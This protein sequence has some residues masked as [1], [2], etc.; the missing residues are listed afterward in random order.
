MKALTYI[1]K[2]TVEVLETPAP[3]CGPGEVVIKVHAVGICGSDLGGY[4]GHHSRRQPP[5][6]LGHELAGVVAEVGPG[7]ERVREGDR[8]CANP[9]FSCGDCEACRAGH[10]NLC[11]EWR[12]LGMDRV[13]G[14]M[15]EYVAVPSSAIRPIRP[16]TTDEQAA[17]IE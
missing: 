13:Q 11:P 16:E 17:F 15:A 1:A 10:P 12:L 4:L 8:V 5:L 6:V 9:L 2:E 14:A 7:V 3:T